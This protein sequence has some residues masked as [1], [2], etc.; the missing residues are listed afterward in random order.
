MGYDESPAPRVR[1]VCDPT[2][3]ELD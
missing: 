3:T 1:Q 2:Q